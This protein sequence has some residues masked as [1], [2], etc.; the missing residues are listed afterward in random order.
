MDHVDRTI[1][2]QLQDNAR[3]SNADLARLLD[4]AP[5]AIHAR[6]RKLEDSGVIRGYEARVDPSALDL[7]LLAFVSVG[8]SEF[9]EMNSGKRLAAIP[10][11]ME[12]HHVAGDD[13]WLI[14]VR[15]PNTESLGRLLNHTIGTIENVTSTRT[16]IVLDSVK[17]SATMPVPGRSGDTEA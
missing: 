6:I 14:K 10:E 15:T 2:A 9:G 5:S 1:L 8:V 17:E 12:V 3:T 7:G 16:T 4:M 11:V 13:C